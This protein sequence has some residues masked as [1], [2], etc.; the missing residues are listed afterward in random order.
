MNL[1]IVS[2]FDCSPSDFEAMMKRFEPDMEGVVDRWE[3]SVINEH[4]V[5]T[6]MQVNDMER[7]H[8]LMTDPRVL[9]W[10]AANNCKDTVYKLQPLD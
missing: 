1:C 4:K 8:S 5:V 3:M 10:D 2:T 9:E 6:M 7:L